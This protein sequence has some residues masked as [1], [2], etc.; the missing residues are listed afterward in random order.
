MLNLEMKYNK[1]EHRIYKEIKEI[2]SNPS[3]LIAIFLLA[4]ESCNQHIAPTDQ[5]AL[6]QGT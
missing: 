2:M 3:S 1:H 4:L 6:Q 5:A